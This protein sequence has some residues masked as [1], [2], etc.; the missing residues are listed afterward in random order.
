VRVRT[1]IAALAVL[2][3][4]G[5]AAALNGCSKDKGTNP[6]PM[7]TPES[8]NSGT[9]T[10]TP[11]SH[12]FNTAGTYSYRCVFHGGAPNYMTGTVVV[13]ASSA[14]MTAGVGVANFAFSPPS[15]TIKPGG[16]V[17][18]TLGGGTHSVTRP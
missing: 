4:V 2:T 14:S 1:L 7:T 15:V 12:T 8:F 18:W 3:V 16:T 13:D 11:F 9:L 6:T 10:S 5:A 17:T